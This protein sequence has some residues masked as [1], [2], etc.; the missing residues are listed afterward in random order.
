MCGVEDARDVSQLP[1]VVLACLF[2]L[3]GDVQSIFFKFG[4]RWYVLRL[5]RAIAA[6]HLKLGYLLLTPLPSAYI[7]NYDFYLMPR[8]DPPLAVIHAT[9]SG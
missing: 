2:I 3:F 7:T 8:L 4:R 1:H 6:M 9:R 5:A